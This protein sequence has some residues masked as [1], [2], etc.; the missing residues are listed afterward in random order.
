L[1]GTPP[2]GIR[3][4]ASDLDG[5][6]L[7]SDG[8]I[9]PRTRAAVE[10]A[11]T[12]GLLVVFVTGRPPRWLHEVADGTGHTGVAV[13]ANGAVIYDLERERTVHSVELS[14]AELGALTG[15]L[16]HAFPDVLFALEYGENFGF[17]PGYRHDWEISPTF[18]RRG[19]RIP[20]PLVAQLDELIAQPAVKLLAKDYE[21]DPDEFL[22]EAERLLS[23]RASVTHS[24][25]HGLIEIAA[26]GV[27]KAT[28]LAYVAASHGIEPHEIVAIGDMPNDLPMLGWVGRGYA[29]A[30]AHPAVRAAADEV[31]GSNDDDAVAVLLESL[32]R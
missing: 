30:N 13:A 23:G 20:P 9:S 6:L 19:K 26:A 5:T 15:E 16:R 1:P 4:V 28:G 31:V 29:V 7:R 21:A 14:P 25:R 27:T 3:L 11:V 8:T 12:A 22:L 32:T 24:S 10:A 18:D 17:E 2:T